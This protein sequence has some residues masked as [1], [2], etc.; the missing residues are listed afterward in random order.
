MVGS[1]M[2]TMHMDPTTVYAVCLGGVLVLLFAF[3]C[4]I[5]HFRAGLRTLLL[6]ARVYLLDRFVLRR[7][8]LAGPWTVGCF[9]AQAIYL[10][11][12]IWSL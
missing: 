7:H 11:G 3:T 5:P 8:A 4:V 1:K 6:F 2:R 12:N 9:L 10:G